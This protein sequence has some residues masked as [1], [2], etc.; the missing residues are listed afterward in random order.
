MKRLP[1]VSAWFVSIL[2]VVTSCAI[3]PKQP[4]LQDAKVDELIPLRHFFIS[5][6]TRFGFK[7]SP[8]GKK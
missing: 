2:F 3:A 8:D 7:V 4:A 5:K 6:E 1:A